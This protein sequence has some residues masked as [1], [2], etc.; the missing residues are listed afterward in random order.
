MMRQ[1]SFQLILQTFQ[2]LYGS[3][4]TG[5]RFL[6]SQLAM[7]DI[8]TL[9]TFLKYVSPVQSCLNPQSQK[10]VWDWFQCFKNQ[11]KS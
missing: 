11:R 10:P 8:G 3:L 2:R 5:A 4:G 6:R 7:V 9:E 1:N